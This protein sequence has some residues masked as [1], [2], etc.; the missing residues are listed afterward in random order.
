MQVGLPMKGDHYL[1]SMLLSH[2]EINNKNCRLYFV[3]SIYGDFIK[4]EQQHSSTDMASSA[5][6]RLGFWLMGKLG[7]A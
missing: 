5:G 4:K 1:S 2:N 7:R 3:S 6:V